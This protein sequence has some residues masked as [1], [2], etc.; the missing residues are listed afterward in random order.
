MPAVA[1]VA[2]HA[3]FVRPARWVGGLGCHVLWRFGNRDVSPEG[4]L[5]A[6][7][8]GIRL[9]W[10]GP[11]A[12]QARAEELHKLGRLAEAEADLSAVL[13][14]WPNHRG[15]LAVRADVRAA[16]GQLDEAEQDLDA[17]EALAPADPAAPF[18][19]G[20]MLYLAG[21]HDR[22]ADAFERVVQLNPRHSDGRL[23]RAAAYCQLGLYDLAADE[24]DHTLTLGLGRASDFFWRGQARAH[25]REFEA[26]LADFDQAVR[27]DPADVVN[28]TWRGWVLIELGRWE[29]A[30]AAYDEA[31]R[32]N[33]ANAHAYEQRARV[34]DHL[35]R[36]DRAAADFETCLNLEQ[37]A[38]PAPEMNTPATDL[39]P[40]VRSH[41]NEVPLERLA[42]TERFFPARV[43][44]DAQRALDA[45]ADTEFAVDHFVCP[46]QNNNIVYNF[47]ALYS[48]DRRNPITA[49]APHHYEVDI[50][51]DKPVRC[52]WNGVW[53]LTHRDTRIA[54]L[55]TADQNHRRFQVAA[56]A[57]P[58][59]EAATAAFLALIEA[60]VARGACYRGKVLS[61]E[62]EDDHRGTVNGLKVHRLRPVGRE[63]VILPRAT[64]DL[65][66]RN[67][68]EFVGARPRLRDLGLATRKG[69]LFHGPPGT[70][71]THTIHYLAAA[72][73]GTTTFLIS[74]EQVGY[75]AE[76]MTLA[77]LFQ[78]SLVVLEDV[79]L[80]ARERRALRSGVEETLLNRLLNE[81]DG[82]KPDADILFVL[83]TN[84]PAAL[85]D[86]LANRPGRVDQ[87]I[88]F[89]YPDAE[90]RA[91]L[92]RMYAGKA[93]LPEHLV[94]RLVTGTADT[95]P[96][97]IKELMR[98]AAQYAVV[99]GR[100]SLTEPDVDGAL[101]EMQ[102]SGVN[103]K[104]FGF[105]GKV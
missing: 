54:V 4:R 93:E 45:L 62:A 44:A 73:P 84:A 48:R 9:G 51:E 82:L 66:D 19:R 23:W 41:F 55:T 42:L 38:N 34:W 29:E 28:H 58:E 16:L 60:A 43:S 17:L 101:A 25:L 92:V 37:R 100:T 24:V 78:P 50:G 15:T 12:R 27:L 22:A 30:R 21:Q 94:E 36:D 89:P 80:I 7:E 11:R 70:G 56:P 98:R 68:I 47:Q 88:E 91:R 104:L 3:V 75:L 59:G 99:R 102:T 14:H 13:R 79:D 6:V 5:G 81:M 53:L 2:W 31:I 8:R 46:K 105:G 57:T 95:S 86:A 77:R 32:L 20:R 64:L 90:G 97:F 52:L 63:D 18:Q 85:E 72:L 49:A 65:L 26:A 96:A 71:K 76:Y 1:R 69:I 35:G 39:Y 103:S 40:L 61:L 33:P 83:T 74:A 67:V 10:D 87:A